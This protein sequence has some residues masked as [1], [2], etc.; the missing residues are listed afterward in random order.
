MFSRKVVFLFCLYIV[1]SWFHH[2]VEY[3]LMPSFLYFLSVNFVKVFSYI[4]CNDLYQDFIIMYV[5]YFV[6]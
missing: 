3:C 4:S 6:S 5:L 2:V 1:Q